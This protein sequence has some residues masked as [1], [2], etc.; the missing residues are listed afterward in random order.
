MTSL[1]LQIHQIHDCLNIV[2]DV[3]S[4]I[5]DSSFKGLFRKK[6]YAGNEGKLTT[7]LVKLSEIH[8]DLIAYH[9]ESIGI[10]MVVEDAAEYAFALGVTAAQLIVINNK[11]RDKANGEKY[12]MSEYQ[13]GLNKFQH[14]QQQYLSLGAKLNAD[15]KLYAYEIAKLK[16]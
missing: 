10:N 4:D 15:Y 3:E 16:D 9:T 2:C 1:L 6:D 12:S 14:L 11:L 8:D 5:F 7:A 13:E